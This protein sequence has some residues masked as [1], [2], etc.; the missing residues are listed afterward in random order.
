MSLCWFHDESM[1]ILWGYV[2]L[3]IY[4]RN[5]VVECLSIQ[6]NAYVGQRCAIGLALREQPFYIQDLNTPCLAT[7]NLLPADVLYGCLRSTEVACEEKASGWQMLC[8]SPFRW[9]ISGRYVERWC[10]GIWCII[11][12]INGETVAI[13]FRRLLRLVD[14]LPRESVPLRIM[15]RTPIEVQVSINFT[16][17]IYMSFSRTSSYFA[18]NLVSCFVICLSF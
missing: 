17:K 10:M 11:Y 8:H 16:K 15:A 1:L 2:A 6:E 7:S 5:E 13:I 14:R 3:T 12:A 9:A 4:Y 18:S